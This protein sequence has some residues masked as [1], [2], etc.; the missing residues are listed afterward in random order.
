MNHRPLKIVIVGGGAAGVFAAAS[1][2]RNCPGVSVT[3]IHDPKIPYIGVGE[4]LGFTSRF[5][6][7]DMLGFDRDEDWLVPSRS[8]FKHGVVHHGFDGT[9]VPH[10]SPHFFQPSA[11]ILNASIISAYKHMEPRA[12]GLP[13][14]G[15]PGDEYSMIDIWLHLYNRGLR[16]LDQR[17]SDLSEMYW[18]MH[19][20]TMPDPANH[21]HRGLTTSFHYKHYVTNHTLQ[22]SRYK[23]H[24]KTSRNKR[25]FT[26]QNDDRP[27]VLL[28]ERRHGGLPRLSFLHHGARS[29]TEALAKAAE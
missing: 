5:F 19:Y 14:T 13:P 8:T 3:M 20:S 7:R 28:E 10:Y 4:S 24:L 9:D 26:G 6:M 12:V 1:F 25:H 16:R 22:V 11:K 29:D 18:Y 27:D 17:E 2:L 21:D 23:R 15:Q